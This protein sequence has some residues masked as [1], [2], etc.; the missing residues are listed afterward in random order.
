MVNIQKF[1]YWKTI[2]LLAGFVISIQSAAQQTV[3]ILILSGKNNHNWQKTTPVL[4]NIF[5]ESGRFTVSLSNQPDTLTFTDYKKF[6]LIISNRNSWPDTSARWDPSK[7]EG[8]ERY[9]REGGGS[10]SFHAGGSSFYGWQDYHSIT[11]GRWGKNTSHGPIGPALIRYSGSQNPITRGLNDFTIRDEIWE[12]TDINPSAT[13]LGWA[14]KLNR[15]PAILTS[16]YGKGRCFYTILGH[17]EEVL[18]NPDLQ[19]L[20][21]QAA[22]WASGIESSVS[23][24]FGTYQFNRNRKPHF[25]PLISPA[26]TVLTQESPGDHLWHMGLWFSWKFID[27]LNYW[28]YAGDA[29]RHIS[30]GMTDIL[31]AVADSTKNGKYKIRLNIIYHPW[32][33]KDQPVLDEQRRITISAPEKDGSY[34]IDYNLSFLA[35]KDLLLDRTPIPGEENGQSWGGYSG[36]SIRLNNE[37]RNIRYF[38][39]S[40]DGVTY[41]DRSPWVACEFENPN[42]NREQVIIF[43]D[44]KNPRYPSPWYCI[45]DS[46]TPM[47]YFSPAILYKKPIQLS[48][49]EF[50]HLK[51]RVYL[52]ARTLTREEIQK[53]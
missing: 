23:G 1:P 47:F 37:F 53:L 46:A 19:H 45:N 32:D 39:G 15:Y 42:G 13:V 26:G 52:P 28:E 30:E 18:S 36:L 16:R 25:H 8:F 50:L 49:G 11:I 20:L 3:P 22:I 12:K 14:Q 33:N 5:K 6:R 7:E 44:A 43:D 40:S 29:A 17:D 41:G 48:K 38:S 4:E 2:F 35:L 34:W 31:T 10:L 27:G 21:V 9:M 24:R 51:Y